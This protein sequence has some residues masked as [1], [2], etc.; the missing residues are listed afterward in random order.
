ME[1]VGEW[2]NNFPLETRNFWKN[3]LKDIDKT[4]EIR[5]R[6]DKPVI[7]YGKNR[8]WYPDREGNRTN[9]IEEAGIIDYGGIQKLVD[10]WCQDSRYAYQ[11]EFKDGYLTLRG[12]HR[13]GICGEAVITASE[14]IE[15]IKNISAL[16]I[17]IAHEQ[18][19]AGEKMISFLYEDGELHNTL[20]ISPPGGGK[21]TLLRDLVRRISDGNAYARGK[22]TGLV[23]E[24]GEIAACFQGIPQLDVGLR[25]DVLSGC[26]KEKGMIRL[27]RAMGP[28]VIAVDE[29]GSIEEIKAVQRIIG[30][31]CSILATVHGSNRQEIRQKKMFSDLL[32]QQVFGRILVLKREEG[33]F[34]CELYKRGDELPCTTC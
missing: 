33:E 30:C 25:T 26:P 7:L 19:N 23:D 29:L 8:E 6:A 13:I 17:R 12:G 5:I 1:A 16:N 2:I 15:T 27:L 34:H 32:E 3:V 20:I 11:K 4:E 9:R 28:Q 21:T 24:R 18:K 22:T 14:E 31:G 10:Y